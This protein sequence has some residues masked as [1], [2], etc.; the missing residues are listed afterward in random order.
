MGRIVT[1]AD[2]RSI[3]VWDAETGK[4]LLFI[5]QIFGSERYG[6]GV[7][8]CDVTSDGSL[9]I[10]EIEYG[11][12]KKIFDGFTGALIMDVEDTQNTSHSLKFSPN[13]RMFLNGNIEVW[14]CSN[15]TARHSTDAIP[16]DVDRNKF[17]PRKAAT[18]PGIRYACLA[19]TFSPDNKRVLCGDVNGSIYV[20]D[21]A[22][23][24]MSYGDEVKCRGGG[25]ILHLSYCRDQS[26][27][28]VGTDCALEIWDAASTVC[29][30]ISI[31]HSS[32]VC[33]VE[34]SC[35]RGS[36]LVR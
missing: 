36:Q 9:I 27:F 30:D 1:L 8:T 6:G 7:G 14:S 21:I 33:G 31:A 10:C 22:A 18:L 28:A 15:L 13:S 23:A 11:G 2:D 12:M 19:S 32:A 29:L 26:F 20:W 35:K 34:F 16:V 17:K 24:C 4:C 25:R 3:K 5:D